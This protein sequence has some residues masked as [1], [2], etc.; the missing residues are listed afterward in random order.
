MKRL[1]TKR[2]ILRDLCESD[3][4][5][6]FE[7]AQNP[8]IGPAAGWKPHTSKEESLRILR[9]LQT[10]NDVW[11]IEHQVEH[12]MIGTIGLHN[13]GK[14]NHKHVKA[15]GYVLHEA[16]WG[17]GLI[18]EAAQAVLDYA[19]NDL[20]LEL[21]S[22]YHFVFNHQSRRVAVKCG[23][24]FEGILRQ[25]HIHYDGTIMDDVCH[26]LTKAEYNQFKLMK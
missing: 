17:Q 18:V 4:D 23:F 26:S 9:I 3:L 5:D 2:L 7:Y 8:K 11:A 14:R 6:F 19:F 20:N 12:K 10:Q 15:I 24:S 22:L 25:A 13:D 21:V 1:V 16:Y